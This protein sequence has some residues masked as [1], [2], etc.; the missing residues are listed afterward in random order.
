M[1]AEVTIHS[2]WRIFIKQCSVRRVEATEKLNKA[3][4]RL[5]PLRDRVFINAEEIS[6]WTGIELEGYFDPDDSF[7]YKWLMERARK[8]YS[9]TPHKFAGK[10][11]ALVDVVVMCIEIL[12]VRKL[13]AVIHRIDQESNIGFKDYREYVR[14]YYMRVQR[15]LIAGRGYSYG[16]CTGKI[17]VIR[18]IS[19][20]GKNYT[21]R[22]DFTATRRRKEEIIA[23]GLRPF[24]KLEAE[25]AAK[26]GKKYDGIDYRVWLTDGYYYDLHWANCTLPN[27][28]VMRLVRTKWTGNIIRDNKATM[29]DVI[30]ELSVEDIEIS[31]LD[32]MYK[33]N[34]ITKKEP[35]L[36]LRYVRFNEQEVY[37]Y[38]KGI[39][40][41][42]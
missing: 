12:R 6:K 2:Y 3:L 22:I 15:E 13:N 9:E 4:V 32:L 36:G 39:G 42:R 25:Y 17:Y 21:G 30:R 41:N 11:E 23:Q 38:R 37:N 24:D 5:E 34:A 10:R 20:G 1:K 40:K 18:G 7:N 35:H 31:D 14:R 28:T 33:V 16:K 19:G 8:I 26:N 27:K 29:D